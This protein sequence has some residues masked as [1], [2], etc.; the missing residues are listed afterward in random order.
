MEKLYFNNITIQGKF[1]WKQIGYQKEKDAEFYKLNFMPFIWEWL[2][3][4]VLFSG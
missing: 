4:T 1:K 2:V 3:I